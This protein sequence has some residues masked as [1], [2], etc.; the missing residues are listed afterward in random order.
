MDKTLKIALAAVAVLFMLGVAFGI[1]RY[2]ANLDDRPAPP[3]QQAPQ[4]QIPG[5]AGRDGLDGKP[6]LPG[7]DG[8]DGLDGQQGIPGR[9]GKDGDPGPAGRPGADGLPGD[10]GPQGPAGKDGQ[11]GAAGPPGPS[12]KDGGLCPQ[13]Y[14][15]EAASIIVVH[16]ASGL[17]DRYADTSICEKEDQGG[18]G[19]PDSTGEA[20]GSR[21]GED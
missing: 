9:D 14:A 21:G 4:P 16:P 1:G 15:P 20:D 3:L 19:T 13:G 17:P 12:G 11:D 7:K 5:P 8:R 6:G 10:T 18:E 2:S